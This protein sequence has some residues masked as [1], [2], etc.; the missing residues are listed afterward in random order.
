ML[1]DAHL[2]CEVSG[3]L[4]ALAFNFHSMGNGY[5]R[6]KGLAGAREN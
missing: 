6:R 5:L 4:D 1:R 3:T 2:I